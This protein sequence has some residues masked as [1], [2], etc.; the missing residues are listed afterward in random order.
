LHHA[1]LGAANQCGQVSGACGEQVQVW[2]ERGGGG[3]A[4]P[5]TGGGM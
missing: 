4:S 3:R 5:R 2:R 1:L